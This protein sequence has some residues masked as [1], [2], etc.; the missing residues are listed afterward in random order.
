MLKTP[1]IVN[2]IEEKLNLTKKKKISIKFKKIN[3]ERLK[4][5]IR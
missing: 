1:R 3:E 2:Q 5:K 4:K